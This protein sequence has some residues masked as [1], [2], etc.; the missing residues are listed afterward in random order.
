MELIRL[1]PELIK[2]LCLTS[3]SVILLLILTLKLEQKRCNFSRDYFIIFFCVPMALLIRSC[4]N[5]YVYLEKTVGEGRL[6]NWHDDLLFEVFLSLPS[7]SLEIF[8]NFGTYLWPPLLVRIIMKKSLPVNVSILCAMLLWTAA[9]LTNRLYAAFARGE[10]FSL[11]FRLPTAIA[12]MLAI[13][14]ILR[15]GSKTSQIP[16]PREGTPLW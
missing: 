12:V 5:L 14:L 7:M 13:F 16:Q 2:D 8:A 15:L 11:Y 4:I 6:G 9:H 1:S 3:L 10:G